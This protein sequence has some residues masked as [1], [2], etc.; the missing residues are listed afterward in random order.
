M[1][2]DIDYMQLALDLAAKGLGEVE[3]NPAVGCVTVK[4]G[5]I[6]GTGY[7]EQFGGPHAEV[8]ALADCKANGHDPAGATMYVTLEPCSHTGKTPPCAKAVG[9][10]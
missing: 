9:G 7:H 1:Q 4:G 2:T 10:D 3:P 8:N 6:I 5:Q